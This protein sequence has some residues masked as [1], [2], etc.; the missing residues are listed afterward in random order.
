MS[1]SRIR[2]R[3]GPAA[4]G[5]GVALAAS[6]V[7]LVAS[8]LTPASGAAQ[9]RGTTTTY[10]FNDAHFH[11]TN[12]IQEGISPQKFLQIMGSRVGRS[13]LFGIPLQQQWS[14]RISGDHAPT[15]YLDTDARLY[16]YSFTDAY[17]A[18]QYRSLS[19]AQQARF[20]PMITGFNPTDMYAADHIRRVL[21]TFPGV[22]S[23]IGEFSIHKEFVS[24][25]IAGDVASLTDPALDRLLDFAAEVGLVVLIHN[26]V[27]RPFAK[28]G[29]PPV[30]LE[31]FKSLLR[32]HPNNSII[33]AHVGLGRVIQPV[34]GHIAMLEDIL[35]DP[36]CGH[37]C[38]D[39]SWDEVAKYV[40]SS[41]EATQRTA[42]MINKYP[43]R[44]L[45]GTDTV[46][47]KDAQAYY[48]VYEMYEPLWKLLSPEVRDKVLKKN[49]ERIFDEGR[50][51]ARAW[52]KAH[53]MQ[54]G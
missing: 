14:Y 39:I 24:S 13:T 27:D 16:Y 29:E 15:Y 52:E 3:R 10:Q 6:V 47:P 37:V 42:D 26:D 48:A 44:F 43:D 2:F 41:P 50:R 31:Q 45:F 38:F 23:G 1:A 33:W 36:V 20:D 51:N 5:L 7:L 28:K 4:L 40:V 54:A 22:F 32:R 18:M 46:A 49:Y 35:E 30:F 17:I 9:P 21:Q 25:K 11:L 8:A 19:K 53:P 34:Q 12:Y